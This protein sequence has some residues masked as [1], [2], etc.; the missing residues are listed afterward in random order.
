MFALGLMSALGEYPEGAHQ[1]WHTLQ[2]TLLTWNWI[3]G[4]PLSVRFFMK[5]SIL[6][7]CF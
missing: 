3:S 4:M 7:S 2:L 5:P 6:P 1:E